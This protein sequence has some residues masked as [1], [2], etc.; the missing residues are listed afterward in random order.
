ML[1]GHKKPKKKRFF[2]QHA[3]C[4]QYGMKAKEPG[5]LVQVDHMT[6]Y[7]NSQNIKDFKAACPVTK[8]M[9]TEVYNQATSHTAK[10]FLEKMQREFPFPIKSIQKEKWG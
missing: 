7:C 1:V 6:V 8:I 10:Q 4:W 2:N 3:K 9:V 5:E